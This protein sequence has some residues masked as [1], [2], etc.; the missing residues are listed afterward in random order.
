MRQIERFQL[1]DKVARELQSRMTYSDID[2][3]L[4]GFGI[5]FPDTSGESFGS[6]WVY[7][8]TLLA[9]VPE[10]T[11]IRIADELEIAHPYVLA[12][13]G[14]SESRF[15]EPGH[16][17]LF[18]S[19]LSAFKR[20]TGALQRA[21]RPFGISSFVAH[22][23][24]EPTREWQSEIESA[25]FSMDALVAVLMTG[26]KESNWTDQEVG[27]AI[28][29]GIL[30]IPVIKDLD[31]YGFI[32]K[33][34]GLNARGMTV[35]AVA[36]GIFDIIVTSEKTR[37]KMLS[38]LIDTA[39]LAESSDEALEKLQILKSVKNIP[40]AYLQRFRDAAPGNSAYEEDSDLWNVA[41]EFLISRGQPPLAASARSTGFGFQDIDGDLPF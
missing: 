9:D 5:D 29:R 34:Q 27:V 37:A 33:Y 24:I 1:I 13:Q 8:K 26:L 3:Y 18:L 23:D 39:V 14:V 10:E 32:G 20:K 31:P 22:V 16:F 4:K 15:W 19:H 30:V 38:A 41:N 35:G 25:L 28:G 6:K 11:L 7:S 40:A 36:R 17:R 2:V 12:Y 21:L